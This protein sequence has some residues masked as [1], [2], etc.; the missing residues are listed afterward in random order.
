M[1]ETFPKGSPQPTSGVGNQKST[2]FEEKKNSSK[3]TYPRSGS[4][5]H[6]QGNEKHCT[7]KQGSGL[8]GSVPCSGKKKFGTESDKKFVHASKKAAKTKSY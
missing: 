3:R 2:E 6:F 4:K 1:Y 7:L 5:Q 8:M